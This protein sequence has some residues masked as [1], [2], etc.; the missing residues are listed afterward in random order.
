M[1]I[2]DAEEAAERN[3][4]DLHELGRTQFTQENY[5]DAKATFELI[6]KNIH[7]N[8]SHDYIYR[9]VLANLCATLKRLGNSTEEIQ[10]VKIEYTRLINRCEK[11]IELKVNLTA[12]KS[13]GNKTKTNV[14]THGR[15]LSVT[16][17]DEEKQLTTTLLLSQCEEMQLDVT[18]LDVCHAM[19]GYGFDQERVMHA[20]LNGHRAPPCVTAKAFDVDGKLGRN[21][22][23]VRIPDG[24]FA[25]DEFDIEFEDGSTEICRCPDTVPDSSRV[26]SVR[27]CYQHGSR[28]PITIKPIQEDDNTFL[29]QIPKE[30]CEGEEVHIQFK[31]GTGATIVCPGNLEKNDR[32]LTLS[33]PGREDQNDDGRT[34][35]KVFDEDVER[36]GSFSVRVP[37][38]M[39]EG[40]EFIVLCSEGRFVMKCPSASRLLE[41]DRVIKTMKPGYS[42]LPAFNFKMTGK[43]EEEFN[44]NASNIWLDPNNTPPSSGLDLE[45]DKSEIPDTVRQRQMKHYIMLQATLKFQE[46]HPELYP[47]QSRIYNGICKNKGIESFRIHQIKQTM[48]YQHAAHGDHGHG[49]DM[50]ECYNASIVEHEEEMKQYLANNKKSEY[51]PSMHLE[52]Q[53]WKSSEAPIYQAIMWGRKFG[54]V[55]S[56]RDWSANPYPLCGPAG[57]I[58]VANL[59]NQKEDQCTRECIYIQSPFQKTIDINGQSKT[60]PCHM[61]QQYRDAYE[62]RVALTKITNEKGKT[63]KMNCMIC[64]KETANRCGGCNMVLFCSSEH[65]KKAWP[66]HKVDCKGFKKFKKKEKLT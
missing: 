16:Q 19:Q 49:D 40:E 7:H 34:E 58:C 26:I 29:L 65:Q 25:G 54:N 23:S 8:P 1:E 32:K 38:G 31:D 30:V 2:L 35:V 6:L 57:N 33:K 15:I 4:A 36:K 12:P 63:V 18:L 39:K 60:I 5:H 50:I 22:L 21:T 55:S 27:Y 48:A 37:E 3:I 61:Q 51:L 28:E 56:T 11:K 14:T 45:S 64:S 13:N 53:Y 41:T 42:N 66:T 62:E 47:K 20:L 17:F 24:I 43:L 59:F 9:I 10:Q 46:R 52:I 44:K